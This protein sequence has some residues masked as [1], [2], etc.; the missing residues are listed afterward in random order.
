MY[1]SNVDC[2]HVRIV[3]MG[4]LWHPDRWP[5]YY[6]CKYFC[7]VDKYSKHRLHASIPKQ[8][9]IQSN[10]LKLRVHLY[11]LICIWTGV[12]AHYQIEEKWF[13]REGKAIAR[14]GYSKIRGRN[15]WQTLIFYVLGNGIK[16]LLYVSAGALT[17]LLATIPQ[18]GSNF[19]SMVVAINT[20]GR[21]IFVVGKR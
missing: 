20:M 18:P 12:F 21:E 1:H 16:L 6:H 10:R 17:F 11:L 19:T 3:G 4:I 14:K 9:M 8:T 7:V 15:S 5:H 13:T 2:S